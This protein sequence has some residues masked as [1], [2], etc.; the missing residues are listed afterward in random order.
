MAKRKFWTSEKLLSLSAIFISLCTLTVLIYQANLNR[1]YQHLSVYP[2]LLVGHQGS[3]GPNYR[4]IIKNE[5]IGPAIISSIKIISPEK[6]EFDDFIDYVVNQLGPADTSMGFFH[7]NLNVGRMIPAN[8]TMELIGT[9][10]GKSTTSVKLRSLL[11][12]DGFQYEIK[13]E[14]IYGDEWIVT[15]KSP[16]PIEK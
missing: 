16:I 7:T 10:D 13:Y 12:G 11:A 5:G 8:Q 4:F 2:Y 6:E 1:Q 9:T 3:G 14:S 15:H